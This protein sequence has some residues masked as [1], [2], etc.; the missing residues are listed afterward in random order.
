MFNKRFLQSY[1]YQGYAE[2]SLAIKDK[3]VN[4]HDENDGVIDKIN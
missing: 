3:W 4:K 1:K 2:A